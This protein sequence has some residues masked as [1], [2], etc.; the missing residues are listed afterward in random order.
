M[1]NREPS[2][3][4][5]Q[6]PTVPRLSFS[7]MS[8]YGECSL[9]YYFQYIEKLKLRKPST[10]TDFGSVIHKG[11]EVFHG[12]ITKKTVP[13]LEVLLKTF[14]DEWENKVMFSEADITPED[15][16][17]YAEMGKELLTIYY[18]DRVGTEWFVPPVSVE[19]GYTVPLVDFATGEL[20][21]VPVLDPKTG[22]FNMI[23]I[24]LYAI[25]DMLLIYKNKLLVID[26]KTSGR[27]YSDYKIQTSLQL[28]IY[29]YVIEYLIRNELIDVPKD[30]EI[31]V[32]FNVFHKVKK[33]YVIAH[34]ATRTPDDIR[35]ALTVAKKM[36][37]GVIKGVFVPNDGNMWCESC[38][39]KEPCM[40]WG[41]HV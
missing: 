23:D 12:Q 33:P 39:Y 2:L 35:R 21:S 38:D 7:K 18:N 24:D 40:N 9:K 34:M 13:G 8:T 41:K 31:N 10:A 37:E 27:K 4:L 32:C 6:I 20:I 30:I 22:I 19:K 15:S 14:S 5:P 1:N 3:I 29:Q 17:K 36:V 16:T 28:T 26:H 11:L 25:I